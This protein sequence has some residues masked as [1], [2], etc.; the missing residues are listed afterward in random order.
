MLRTQNEKLK[1]A[2]DSTVQ[3]FA[4]L[5]ENF[6]ETYN[7]LRSMLHSMDS[8]NNTKFKGAMTK[9]LEKKREEL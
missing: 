4:V 5:F 9:A 1:A 3:K 7:K 8:D 2:S 6:S